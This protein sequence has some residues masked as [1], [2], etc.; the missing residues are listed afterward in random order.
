PRGPRAG[1]RQGSRRRVVAREPGVARRDRAGGGGLMPV[2]RAADARREDGADTKRAGLATP[3]LG[4]AELIVC[5]L[6]AALGWH[7]APHSHDR[8]EVVVVTGGT[9]TAML[10]GVTYAVEA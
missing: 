5:S 2:V 10:D 3:S 6:D 8:E 7:G 9:G 4:A 1:A